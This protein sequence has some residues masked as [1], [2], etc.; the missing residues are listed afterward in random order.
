MLDKQTEFILN[1]IFKFCKNNGDFVVFEIDDLILDSPKYLLLTNQIIVDAIKYLNAIN[2]INLK[3]LDEL[4]FC[5]STNSKATAYQQEL[6]SQSIFLKRKNAEHFK[7]GFLGSFLGSIFAV[8]I[9][10]LAYFLR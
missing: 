10:L 4:S 8:L 7:W 5:V 2:F 3:Y 1:Y 6:K 9:F